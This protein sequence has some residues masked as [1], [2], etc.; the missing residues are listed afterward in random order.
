MRY[1]EELFHTLEETTKT[2]EKVNALIQYLS[3][4]PDEDKIWMIAI[5]SGRRP[6]R[7]I[8]TKNLRLWAAEKSGIPLWLFEESY[9]IVGDLSETIALLLPPPKIEVQKSLN[10]WIQ[11]IISLEKR[12]EKDQMDLVY[13]AWDSLNTSGRFIFNKLITGGFRLGVSQKL[14]VKALAQFAKIEPNEIALKLMGDWSPLTYNFET[15]LSSEQNEGSDS[16]PYPFHLA[17]PLNELGDLKEN[18]SD[19]YAEYKWDGIRG[20]CIFRKGKYFLWSRGEEL[21]T[22]KFPEFA[23]F[24]RS[25]PSGTVLDGEILPYKEGSVLPFHHIQ[26]RV[27]RKKITAPILKENPVAFRVYDLLEWKNKDIRSLPFMERRNLLDQLFNSIDAS[28]PLQLSPILSF[29]SFEDLIKLRSSSTENGSE[30]L[31]LKNKYSPYASGR[32]RGEWWKWKID[33]FTVDAILIYAQSGH[34]RRANLYTD[35]TFAVFSENGELLPFTKA[36][37]GLTDKEFLEINHWIKKNTLERF[38]PVRKVTAELV[39]EIAFEGIQ[40]S[41]RHK[42]GIAL[43][44]PR[45]VRWRKDK[46]AAEANTLE[47]LHLLLKKGK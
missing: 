43:R 45:M 14:M 12:E 2:N 29:S 20:Q 27:T 19:W 32:K 21:I 31:M 17:Y 3:S 30:G 41:K 9:H 22:D 44:F 38:G 4:V 16:R 36:Y 35:F 15:L 18:P 24:I 33:P 39:F 23:S 28:L 37:S 10:D 40:E 6:K 25:V 1:F 7:T 13:N 42:S 34:G 5:F 11:Y 46:V 47:D 26:T 8:S